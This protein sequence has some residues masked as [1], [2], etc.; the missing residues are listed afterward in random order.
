MIDSKESKNIS[1]S[2]CFFIVPIW[3]NNYKDFIWSK[4]DSKS[5][6]VNL[7]LSIVILITSPTLFI[8]NESVCFTILELIIWFSLFSFCSSIIFSVRASTAAAF[9]SL[10]KSGLSSNLS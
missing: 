6:P 5:F 10:E 3:D 8:K 7:D 4:I 1:N 9:L 2:W